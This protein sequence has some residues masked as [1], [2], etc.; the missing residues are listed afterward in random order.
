MASKQRRVKLFSRVASY[1]QIMWTLLFQMYGILLQYA[2]H[3]NRINQVIS[4]YYGSRRNA[5]FKSLKQ[6]HLCRSLRKRKSM[7]VKKGR[8]DKWWE[9]MISGLSST[10]S[11]KKNFRMPKEEFLNLCDLLRPFVSPSPASPNYRKLS[12]E[13]KVAL[14]LYYLKDTGS[15]WMTANTFGIHQCTVSKVIHEVCS[16]ITNKLGP[17]YVF[18]PQTI[19]EMEVKAAQFELKFGMVQAFGC[20]DG[21]HIPIKTPAENSQDYFNYKQFHSLNVQAVCDYCGYF[22]DVECVWPGS[23]HDAKV[24]S[25]SK[26]CKRLRNK[27][28]PETYRIVLPGHK[29][30][31]NYVIGDPAYPLT[32]NCLKEYESC[33][34]NAQV[35]FNNMLRSA[36]N[37]I[38]CAFG[39][40]KARWGI[41]TRRIDLDLTKVPTL[42]IACFV[43]HNYCESNRVCLDEELETA[44]LEKNRQDAE[45]F[46]NTPDPMYSGTTV[47]GQ[48]VRDLLTRYINH[49]LPDSY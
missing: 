4:A 48:E 49:N 21:T 5:L 11:W 24:F 22:L 38:E 8:T 9:N 10:D 47:E 26:I 42:I 17:Q 37:P 29:K 15:I 2:I 39:R 43:L 13:K 20:I 31:P 14:T 46:S 18:L 30:I 40:L 6:K 33:A 27:V 34:T 16:A 25:N 23:C 7:W 3:K 28:L 12:L 19:S 35:I 45:V 1:L 36:R 32:P 41:L 44:Q